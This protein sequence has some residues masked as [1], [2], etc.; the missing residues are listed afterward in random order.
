[1]ISDECEDGTLIRMAEGSEKLIRDIRIG[2]DVMHLSYIQKHRTVLF[3]TFQ[4]I[5]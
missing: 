1:M 5:K 4:I 3:L 2:D